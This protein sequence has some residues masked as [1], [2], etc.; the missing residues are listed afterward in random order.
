MIKDMGWGTFLL[1]GI[2][3]VCIAAF[4]WFVL[5]ETQGKSLEEIT[6]VSSS[7]PS[8]KAFIE[9]DFEHDGRSGKTPDVEIK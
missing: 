8:H 4:A 3:D 9:D 5:T 7:T 1:W 2:F 6:N